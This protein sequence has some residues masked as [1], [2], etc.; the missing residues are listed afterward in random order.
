M[1]VH[2]ILK[3]EIWSTYDVIGISQILI[4]TD[5]KTNYR[6]ILSLSL[7]LFLFS[8]SLPDGRP[9]KMSWEAFGQVLWFRL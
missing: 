9:Q 5:F 6:F 7:S 8:I 1:Y 4:S 2:C 3:I